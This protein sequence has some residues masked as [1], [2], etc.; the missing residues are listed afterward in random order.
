MSSLC[1]METLTP[2]S[3]AAARIEYT[4]R[5][6]GPVAIL[7]GG[8]GSVRQGLRVLSDLMVQ[9][10][11]LDQSLLQMRQQPADLGGRASRERTGGGSRGGVAMGVHG[12]QGRQAM[13]LR[14]RGDR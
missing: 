9:P 10:V 1:N 12:F 8:S 11:Q 14:S 3:V 5:A 13:C 2:S 4:E 6:P 7:R